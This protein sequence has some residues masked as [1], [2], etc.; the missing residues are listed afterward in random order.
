MVNFTI[1]LDSAVNERVEG[2]ESTNKKS[3]RYVAAT[4]PAKQK[5]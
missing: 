5:K 4:Y 3:F 1:L 2:Q